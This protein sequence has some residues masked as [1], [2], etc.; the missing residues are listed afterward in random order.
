MARGMDETAGI[1]LERR[2]QLERGWKNS[3][4]GT[5]GGMSKDALIF[6]THAFHIFD[7]APP[8]KKK[9]AC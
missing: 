6:P 1:W 9:N 4:L 5:V 2:D 3:T 8:P 7:M